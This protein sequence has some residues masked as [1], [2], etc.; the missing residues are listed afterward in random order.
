[1]ARA[2]Q[3]P[4]MSYRLLD[5]KLTHYGLTHRDFARLTGQTT[6][7][8]EEWLGDADRIPAWLWTWLAMYESSPQA[9][10]AAHRELDRLTNT[11]IQPGVYDYEQ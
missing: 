11:I 8:V 7:R 5:A 4:R 2:M 10:H 3:W 9:R 1:M 6:R